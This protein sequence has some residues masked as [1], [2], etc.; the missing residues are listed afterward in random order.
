M[1]KQRKGIDIFSL[2]FLDVVSCGFGAIILL[3]VLS[4]VSEPLVVEKMS[5]DLSGRVQELERQ[6]HDIRGESR[7]VNR[8]L[9]AAQQQLLLEKQKLTQQQHALSVLQEAHARIRTDLSTQSRIEQQLEQARQKLSEEMRRLQISRCRQLR[10]VPLAGYRWIANISFLCL[11]PP[12]L[13][14]VLPG[15]WCEKNGRDLDD[16]SP[17]QGYP[18]DE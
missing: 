7:S 6:L 4:K 12:D 18:G 14:S 15:P 10:T 13:C 16:L 11:I 8:Q 2:S 3:L 5:R 9:S 1:K 17:C